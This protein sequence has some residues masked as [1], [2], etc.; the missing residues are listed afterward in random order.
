MK[1]NNKLM[2]EFSVEEL[3]ARYEMKTWEIMVC[4]GPQCTSEI[5]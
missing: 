2:N 4:T 3:E 1:T 5:R